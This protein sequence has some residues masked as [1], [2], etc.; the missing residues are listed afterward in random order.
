MNIARWLPILARYGQNTKELAVQVQR[1]SQGFNGHRRLIGK[2]YLNDAELSQA[3]IR[4]YWPQSY[5]Q[6]RTH[7]EE[8]LDSFTCL[9][10]RIV[11]IGSGPGPMGFAMTD[12]ILGRGG[13]IKELLFLDHSEH[14][15]ALAE[16]LATKAPW[17][18]DKLSGVQ[19]KLWQ[20][21][22]TNAID[23]P[24]PL[25]KGTQWDLL[26]FGHSLNEFYKNDSNSYKKK[27]A[28]LLAI[29]NSMMQESC[30]YIMEPALHGPA[31]ELQALRDGLQSQGI[32]IVGPCNFNGACPAL[33][34]G[35]ACHSQ[36]REGLIS[37]VR[38]LGQA[39]GMHK[40]SVAMSWLAVRKKSV[41]NSTWFRVV[42]ETMLNKAGRTRI[43][44]CGSMGRQNLSC[45]ATGAIDIK[46][47]EA[48]KSLYRGDRIIILDPEARDAGLGI[49][50]NTRIQR[51]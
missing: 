20:L 9:P 41:P 42:G 29:L 51:L 48:F 15:L 12:A 37:P 21:S 31:L 38:K 22:N 35:Q 13:K 45:G 3:Y 19:K 30:I 6:A 16:E 5:I 4:Y 27:L 1:L 40:D 28:M 24:R 7:A 18:T 23:I 33:P 26:C 46:T 8:V 47:L 36:V 10:S 44:L 17:Y 2:K 39:A 49:D 25:E 50:T 43:P 34:L 14:S 32:G 11:D